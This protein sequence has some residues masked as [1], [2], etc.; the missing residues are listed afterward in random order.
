[1]DHC[2]NLKTIT[3][4]DTLEII[5]EG[6]FY[7]H[8]FYGT[9]G[10]QTLNASE[11][12]KYTHPDYCL[13]ILPS[14]NE[15]D[16]YLIKDNILVRYYGRAVR[17]AIP[18]GI[19]SIGP[20]AFCNNPYILGISIPDGVQQISEHAF[21]HCKNLR[22]LILPR[23]LT[24]IGQ[25]AFSYTGIVALNIPAGVYGIGS[26]AFG[27]CMQLTDI[28]FPD[29]LM[30]IATDAFSGCQNIKAIKA[31]EQWKQKNSALVSRLMAKPATV[32]VELT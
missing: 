19:R 25:Y 22:S 21:T 16:N 31:S 30:T 1:M 13:E 23:S 9:K 27:K 8:I 26:R 20:N 6:L 10:I 5:E 28:S 12:W 4:P 17:P 24:R 18:I 2:P 29:S 32:I 14:K 15:A 11:H 3:I 7:P